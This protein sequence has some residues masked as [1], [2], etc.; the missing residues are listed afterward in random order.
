MAY[1]LCCM[2]IRLIVLPAM[3]YW[4]IKCNGHGSVS[5]YMV[6]GLFGIMALGFVLAPMLRP[7]RKGVYWSRKT[8]AIVFAAI[9]ALIAIPANPPAFL[10]AG[11]VFSSAFWGGVVTYSSQF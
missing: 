1:L 8:Y 4:A 6:S 5:R 11:I 10:V 2:P 7:T 3:A 9:A